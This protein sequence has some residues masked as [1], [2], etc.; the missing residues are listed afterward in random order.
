MET[1]VIIVD[2]IANVAVGNGVVRIECV[3]MSATGREKP[4]R[5]MLIPAG[6]AGAVVQSLVNGMQELEKKL[7]GTIA[8]SGGGSP[9]QNGGNVGG[10]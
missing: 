10:L 1:N 4:S 8:A 2:R 7:R 9:S 5:T 3:T 6:V